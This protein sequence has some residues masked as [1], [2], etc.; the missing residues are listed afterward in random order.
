MDKYHCEVCDR[1]FPSAEW[2]DNHTRT[3]RHI[4]NM[5]TPKEDVFDFVNN[6]IDNGAQKGSTGLTKQLYRCDVCKSV[7]MNKSNRDRHVKYSCPGKEAP[8]EPTAPE[9]KKPMEM[10]VKKPEPAAENKKALPTLENKKP[11][12]AKPA[13]E[14]KSRR[15]EILENARMCKMEKR[16]MDDELKLGQEVMEVK[17]KRTKPVMATLTIPCKV[18]FK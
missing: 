11:L 1:N 4:E 5:E 16:Q 2:Q 8:Q 13:K 9:P 7:F 3:K 18:F 10:E 12:P 15:M 17:C 6:W 14:L